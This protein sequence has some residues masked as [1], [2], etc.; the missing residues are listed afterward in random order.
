MGKLC[1]PP[2]EWVRVPIMDMS[3]TNPLSLGPLSTRTVRVSGQEEVQSLPRKEGTPTP[4]GPARLPLPPTWSQRRK[5]PNADIA[6][7]KVS[8][9][10]A[11]AVKRRPSALPSVTSPISH[12][13]L[14]D[15]P[16]DTTPEDLANHIYRTTVDVSRTANEMA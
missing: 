15:S 2:T 1:N 8:G 13:L 3:T 7:K 4:S 14:T 10:I 12:L 11:P 16:M 9:S 5:P 6:S